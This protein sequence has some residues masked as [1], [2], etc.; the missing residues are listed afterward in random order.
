MTGL[1]VSSSVSIFGIFLLPQSFMQVPKGLVEAARIDGG[2]HFLHSL[3]NHL[4][5]DEVVLYYIWFDE[6]HFN[7]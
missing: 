2:S 7:I 1:I 6:L 5:H 3:G 4:P